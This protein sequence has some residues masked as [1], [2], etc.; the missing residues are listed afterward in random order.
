[1]KLVQSFV[2]NNPYYKANLNPTDSRYIKYQKNGPK[3]FMLHSVGC[4]Q[5]KASVFVGAFNKA[6]YT[7]ACVH[8]FIDANDGT[9]HQT[10]PWNF[11]APHAG[12]DANNTHIGIEMCEPDCIKYTGGSSFTCSNK[13][14]A[15]EMAKRTY[16]AAVELFAMLCKEYGYDPLAD[17]VIISHKEG[18]ARGI[19]SAHGDPEHLWRG[20]GLSYTMNTFRK[21]VKA[22]MTGGTVKEET[23]PAVSGST[24][25]R[26]QVGA[27]SQKAN[28]TAQLDKVEAAGFDAIMVK[29]D[30]LYKIQV[31]AF[32]VMSN[33]DNMMA[34][35]EKAGFDAF[36]TTKSGQVVSAASNEY[37]L[38]QFI[39]DVQ[40]AT[41]AAVD[42]SA[43]PETISKTVTLSISKNTRH[44]VVKPVQKRLEE[45][46]YYSGVVDGIFGNQ[47]RAA[48]ISFQRANGCTA[49]GEITKGNK[50]WKKLLGMI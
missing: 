20:L 41:G 45:L 17:G 14:R 16:D 32:A 27:Y 9:I 26:V 24:L 49:D 43:G 46:D 18:N 48:V 7:A 5:P 31:G 4:P 28:A 40:K 11:R 21:D 13:T 39:R 38:D 33:A 36:I 50:T 35:L 3:G 44:A 34:K 25:Y 10:M 15:K 42:G 23:T 8:G 22:A 19:A 6:S 30:G 47:T 37:T 12:G 29:V 2:T 1:M